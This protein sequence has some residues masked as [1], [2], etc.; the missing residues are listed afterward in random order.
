MKWYTDGATQNNGKYG[1]QKSWK[2]VVDENNKV[3]VFEFIG[4]KTN[5]EAEGHSLVDC[6]TIIATQGYPVSEVITDSKFWHNTVIKGWRLK[7][8]RLFPIRDALQKMYLESKGNI[9]FT[10]KMR[11][12]N[13]AGKHIEK[14]YEKRLMKA[15]KTFVEKSTEQL[16]LPLKAPMTI[17]ERIKEMR[18]E[19]GLTQQQLAELAGIRQPSIALLES[20][21]YDKCSFTILRKLA[22][23]LGVKPY[24]RLIPIT[25]K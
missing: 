24:L 11:D 5:I 16:T 7:E 22:T 12:F 20:P 6:F 15:P 10:W 17:N 3:H 25:E 8:K 23:A 14:L 13:L 2:C 21:Q 1:K 19:K 4:D 18:L 9:K